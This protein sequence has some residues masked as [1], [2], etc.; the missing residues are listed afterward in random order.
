MVINKIMKKH[1][2]K[3]V[4]YKNAYFYAIS[5]GTKIKMEKLKKDL[6]SDRSIYSAIIRK[7]NSDNPYILYQRCSKKM[8]DFIKKTH[9]YITPGYN[10]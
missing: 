4:K 1:I 7:G 2:P 3:V 9:P 10:V 6:L 8:A 5:S